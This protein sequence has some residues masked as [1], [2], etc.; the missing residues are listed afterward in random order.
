MMMIYLIIKNKK[1]KLPP[2]L[3]KKIFM[4]LDLTFKEL[5]KRDIVHRDIKPQ[6]ILIK[7]SN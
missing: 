1:K 4:Q 5:N 6:N 2:N 7:Y 3:I